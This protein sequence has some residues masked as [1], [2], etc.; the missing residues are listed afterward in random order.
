MKPTKFKQQNTTVMQFKKKTLF[1]YMDKKKSISC[2]KMSI[3]ERIKTLFTGK[4]FVSLDI[5]LQPHN[6]SVRFEA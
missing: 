4:I 6:L 5:R 1:M 3:L 2:W